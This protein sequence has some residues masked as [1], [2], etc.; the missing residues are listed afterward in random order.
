MS[1]K[2]D[3]SL[4]E[5]RGAKPPLWPPADQWLE[6]ERGQAVLDRIL[7]A[8]QDA[9]V[10][11]RARR[12]RGGWGTVPRVAFAAGMVVVIAIAAVFTILA[13]QRTLDHRGP[14]ASGGTEVTA[15]EAVT[16]EAAVADILPVYA[17]QIDFTF[18][19]GSDSA[20]SPVQRALKLGLL[21]N[22][23]ASGEAPSSLITNGDFALLLAKAFGRS[24]FDT[25]GLTPGPVD[26]QAT[27]E[28]RTAVESLMGSG[29]IR[30][31]DDMFY[32]RR[33]LTR[34]TEQRLLERIAHVIN[35]FDMTT[36]SSSS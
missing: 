4:D 9:T 18:D 28:Q 24:L 30:E 20:E 15:E 16:L 26:P 11:R 3:I 29:I 17:K 6:S 10:Q 31:T 21:T 34:A 27:L 19:Q 23:Q 36:P 32:V 7:A 35:S 13:A 25:D 33:P 5:V 1:R 12:R 2:E 14:V 8:D 22:G